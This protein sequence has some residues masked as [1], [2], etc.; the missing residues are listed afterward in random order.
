M[1]CHGF[2]FGYPAPSRNAASDAAKDTPRTVRYDLQCEIIREALERVVV[3]RKQ[4][5]FRT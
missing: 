2:A 1:P 3:K 4:K 5:C